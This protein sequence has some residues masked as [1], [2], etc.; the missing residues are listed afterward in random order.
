MCLTKPNCEILWYPFLNLV[1]NPLNA[2]FTNGQTHS[3]NS[4]ADANELFA[5]V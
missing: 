4:S 2:K 3:N 1:F 5:C